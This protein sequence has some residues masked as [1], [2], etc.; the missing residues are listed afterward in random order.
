MTISEP[1]AS[2]ESKVGGPA[3]LCLSCGARDLL[4][5]GERIWPLNWRCAVCGTTVPVQHGRPSYAPELADTISGF[6]PADFGKLASFE[7]RHFWF[8]ARNRLICDLVGRWLPQARSLLEIG[9]G[10]GHVLRALARCRSWERVAGSELHPSGLAFAADRLPDAELVQMDAR[11]IPADKVFDII[12]AFDVL[13]HIDEDELVLSAMRR[14]LTPQGGIVVAVPQHPFLWSK[15]DE[16]AHHV[17]RY[18]RG[19]LERKV[20]RAGFRV[21]FSGSYNALLMPLLVASRVLGPMRATRKE[22]ASASDSKAEVHV[23]P[24][25]NG[26]LSKMLGAE[27]ALTRM[28]VRWPVGGSRL[29]VGTDLID[30]RSTRQLH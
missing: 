25:M 10:T 14:A 29:V 21:V 6:D 19:E 16:A 28:G 27:V 24:A 20:E 22:D 2:K 23:A 17:R 1:T 18:G 15:V 26:V 11:F 5:Q 9:C 4:V 3:R 8:G 7:E 13:E 12:G 30:R